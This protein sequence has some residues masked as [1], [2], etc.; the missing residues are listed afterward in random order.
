MFDA[1]KGAAANL[2][3]GVTDAAAEMFGGEQVKPLKDAKDA[4][5][6]MAESLA[7]PQKMLAKLSETTGGLPT[8]SATAAKDQFETL[9]NSMTELTTGD[10]K[11]LLPPGAGCIAGAWAKSIRSKLTVIT[12]ESEKLVTAVKE[13]P[14][15]VSGEL[16]SIKGTVDAAWGGM[17]EVASVIQDTAAT[18]KGCMMSMDKMKTLGASLEEVEGKF[19]AALSK[20]RGSIEAINNSIASTPGTLVTLTEGLIDDIEKYK[21]QTPKKITAAFKPPC[22]CLGGGKVGDAQEKL[23]GGLDTLSQAVN[24]TPLLEGIKGIKTSLEALDLKPAS[25]ALDQAEAAFSKTLAPAKEAASK[26]ADV[27]EIPGAS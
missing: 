26:L 16:K 8:E 24:L 7:G 22:C 12:Q 4:L 23:E 27:P 17:G 21:M 19:Q 3:E 13:T 14:E 11:K 20:S 9:K 25:D 18:L 6:E 10:P 1:I 15:Q 5:G 2:V